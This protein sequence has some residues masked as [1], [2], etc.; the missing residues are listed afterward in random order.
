LTIIAAALVLASGTARAA[1]RDVSIDGGRAPLFGTLETPDG[2]ATSHVAVL[3]LAG[4]GPT[5]RNGNSAL[6]TA[7]NELAQLAHG[8]AGQGVASLRIDKRGIGASRAAMPAEVDM[9]LTTYADDAVAWAD[10][11]RA[12]PGVTCVVIAG[13]SEGALIA[14]LAAQHTEICGVVLL[15]GPGRPLGEVLRDQLAQRMPEP[16]HSRALFILGELE[17]GRTVAD[18][19]PALA[20]LFRPSVQPY[21][22]SEL[23]VDP[24]AEARK[25]RAP[26]LIIQGERDA[27][28]TMVDFE[29]LAA[30]RP[31]ARKLV[32]P[33]MIHP[34]KLLGPG[35][36][37]LS[38]AEV[39]A[40]ALAPGIIEAVTA[41]VR[42]LG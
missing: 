34:L 35:Q 7:P 3:I 28:V 41:F 1:E 8:L 19:D 10:W 20:G 31:D 13:H 6:G 22:I 32:V 40:Q 38:E 25:V 5:D 17:A 29:R 36:T 33:G 4:S 26:L 27:R 11:L 24:A 16:L 2:P 21:F 18:V 9:R 15:E 39:R 14:L 42:A 23:S 30:A 12:Q 37:F